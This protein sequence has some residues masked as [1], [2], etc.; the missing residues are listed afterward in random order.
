MRLRRRAAPQVDDN[1]LK[2]LDPQERDQMKGKGKE[3]EEEEEEEKEE[4]EERKEEE[5]KKK[6][7][8]KEKKEEEKKK[9][10]KKLHIGLQQV[11]KSLDI[12]EG[13][14]KD[15]HQ[16]M[17]KGKGRKPAE[18]CGDTSCSSEPALFVETEKS[19]NPESAHVFENVT[20][21]VSPK[22]K[23]VIKADSS[24]A[25]DTALPGPA[26]RHPRSEEGSSSRSFNMPQ[27]VE[28]DKIRKLAGWVNNMA[29]L[30]KTDQSALHPEVI[31]I[32][33]N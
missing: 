33:I 31:H 14:R 27:E 23:R 11:E 20:L 19:T 8:K 28:S 4:E 30:C 21:I 25:H 7:K 26:F 9:K 32:M 15:R 5:E 12:N 3:K 6:K 13:K 17:I 24:I 16:E 29:I 1:A 10:K 22:K 2:D 18:E